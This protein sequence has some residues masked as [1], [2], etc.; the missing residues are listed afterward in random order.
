MSQYIHCCKE[1][2]T[3]D[4]VECAASDSENLCP[5]KSW[6]HFKCVN[7]TPEQVEQIDEF[8]CSSCAERTGQ[9]TTHIERQEYAVKK[10]HKH[11]IDDRS[12]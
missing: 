9:S 3:D 4:M 5:G 12:G 6:Y 2:K 7:L 1:D 10:I 8:I 11:D